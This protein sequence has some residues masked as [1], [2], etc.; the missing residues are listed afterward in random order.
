MKMMKNEETKIDEPAMTDMLKTIFKHE[1]DVEE[2]IKKQD[3]KM[4]EQDGLIKQLVAENEQQRM[5]FEV[6]YASIKVTAPPPDLSEIR[7]E[8][9]AGLIN[10]NQT[11]DKGPKPIKRL[12]RLTL[13]PEQ[14][15]N[16]GYYRVMLDRLVWIILGSLFLILTFCLLNSRINK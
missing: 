11:I 8:I 5:N 6:K 9:A 14:V 7:G 10:I 15:R 2:F 12:F 4:K 13:F 16:P 1:E 3:V